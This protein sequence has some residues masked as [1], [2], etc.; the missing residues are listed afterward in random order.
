MQRGLQ[1][2][3]R[4]F[5]PGSSDANT[6]NTT[7]TTTNAP[8]R[9]R[10]GLIRKRG[11]TVKI[12]FGPQKGTFRRFLLQNIDI[13][14]DRF[15]VIPALFHVGAITIIIGVFL[16]H[17]GIRVVANLFLQIIQGTTATVML[18]KLRIAVRHDVTRHLGHSYPLVGQR[19]YRGGLAPIP[20]NVRGVVAVGAPIV[21][22]HARQDPIGTVLVVDRRARASVAQR[23]SLRLDRTRRRRRRRLRAPRRVAGAGPREQSPRSGGGRQRPRRT[24]SRVRPVRRIHSKPSSSRGTRG[25]RSRGG[26]VAPARAAETVRAARPARAAPDAPRVHPRQRRRKRVKSKRG[27][28]VRGRS[29]IDTAAGGLAHQ[30]RFGG[31]GRQRRGGRGDRDHPAEPAVGSSDSHVASA[32][33]GSRVAHCGGVGIV[34][35]SASASGRRGT[36]RTLRSTALFLGAVDGFGRE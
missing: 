20:R 2:S 13:P 17:D 28:A 16:H 23:E 4:M 12:Q 25:R 6:T 30:I 26:R 7:N 19:S 11:R 22:I 29:G 3:G 18:G 5:P 31:R 34:V 14:L 21:G 33:R 1:R 10:R 35:G 27:A 36:R 24:R 8:S 15:V 32:A 9:C